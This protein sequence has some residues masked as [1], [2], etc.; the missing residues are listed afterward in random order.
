[1]LTAP[2]AVYDQLKNFFENPNFLA[3]RFVRLVLAGLNIYVYFSGGLNKR[4]DWKRQNDTLKSRYFV[5]IYISL[6]E[7]LDKEEN[8]RKYHK[9]RFT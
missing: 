6:S 1:V 9:I 3:T 5:N 2:T 7:G 4:D 8:K